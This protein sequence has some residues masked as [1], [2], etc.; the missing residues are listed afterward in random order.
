MINK[1]LA[2]F[3]R[4]QHDRDQRKFFSR[5]E[6]LIINLPDRPMRLVGLANSRR[7]DNGL[8]SILHNVKNDASNFIIKIDFLKKTLPPIPPLLQIPCPNTPEIFSFFWYICPLFQSEDKGIHM[9]A[10]NTIKNQILLMFC[11]FGIESSAADRLNYLD[12]INFHI[13]YQNIYSIEK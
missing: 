1:E 12:Y 5:R 13:C 8:S 7:L 3:R 10:L 2:D 4:A 11:R 9:A 6:L